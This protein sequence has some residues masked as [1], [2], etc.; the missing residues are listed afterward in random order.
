MADE[1]VVPLDA[2]ERGDIE[3]AGGKGAALGELVRAAFPV[4]PGFV[5]TITAYRAAIRQAKID[6]A[7]LLAPGDGGAVRE[8][9]TAAEVPAGI[10]AAVIAGYAGLGGG[11][12]AVRSSGTAEDLPTAAFA[13]QQESYLNVIG[14]DAVVDAVRDCWASLWTDRAVRYRERLGLGAD[15]VGLA[16]VVQRMVDAEVAGVMFT[17]DP[18]TGEREVVVVEASA[19]LGEAVVAGLVTPDRYRV[20]RR[21]RVVDWSPGRREVVVR[22]AAGGGVS[23]HR[24]D[25]EAANPQRLPDPT[26]AELAG[27]A[28]RAERHFGRPQDLEWAWAGKRGWLLQSRPMT[29]L[30]PPPPHLN[31]PARVLG[32]NFVEMLPVRPYPMDM[33][34]WLPHGPAGMM[35]QVLQFY[36]LT[37]TFNDLITEEEGVAYALVPH[38]PRPRRAIVCMPVRMA[39]RIRRFDP[40][41]WTTDPRLT[42][43][44][45]RVRELAAIDPADLAWSDLARRPREILAALAPV[46]ALRTDYLPGTAWALL[47][48]VLA[49]V[50]LGRRAQLGDLLGGART[51][52]SQANAALEALAH[53]IRRDPDLQATARQDPARLLDHP[54]F[55]ARLA[56]FLTEYGHRETASA[57]LISPPT[58]GEDPGTVLGLV[59]GLAAA[60][61]PRTSHDP[62]ADPVLAS[63]LAHPRLSTPAARDRMRATVER[64]RRGLAFREDSHFV[65]TSLA[66]VLRR[67]LLEIGRRLGKAEI[68]AGAGVLHAPEEVFHLRL[69]EVEAMGDPGSLSRDQA[70]RWRATVR[71]RMARR[72]ALAGIPMLDPAVLFPARAAGDALVVGTPAG[73]GTATGPVRIIGEP[74]EFGRL[75]R[76]EVLVC[77]YT[78]PS[79]TPLFASAAAVVVDSG[80]LASHAAIV[81]RE[82]AIPAVMGTGTGTTALTDGQWV[83]VDGGT[84]RV[85]AAEPPTADGTTAGSPAEPA[86][87]QHVS[88]TSAGV[89]RS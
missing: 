32:A 57:I 69:E 36:G 11:A 6:P 63:L 5:V 3:R 37:G 46:T 23:H 51:T 42:A 72:E 61:G 14:E 9:I 70:E 12:V 86:E 53:L 77:P 38:L 34:S 71:D 58:W 76:G 75:G 29:A 87:P 55:A 64:A 78:N 84:G 81:A 1:L 40:A 16:V 65:M 41:R 52:T 67:T 25:S 83:R 56:D 7:A 18:V 31:R 28:R 49:L 8:A 19:G 79:W 26:V 21:G 85:S 89:A 68:L 17:A 15:E 88:G 80:G 20:D 27:L 54:T 35:S 50:R 74:R 30:R 62:G 33:T 24:A 45:A 47:R 39:T 73:G 10:R 82:Y 66:P 60:S 59:A 22:T 44:Q 2:V 43:Y 48:L 4:P 13:G